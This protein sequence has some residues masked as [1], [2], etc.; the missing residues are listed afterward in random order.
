MKKSRLNAFNVLFLFLFLG[1][2][3]TGGSK[4]MDHNVTNQSTP[5]IV[6]I[7]MDD[8]GYGDPES[9]GGGPYHTPNMNK[10]AAEGMRFTNFYAAQ[11]VCSASRTGLLTG[12]YPTRVGISGALNH[13]SKI[14]L[15]PAEETIAELLHAKGYRTSMI[16]KWHLG[17]KEPFMPL[18]QGFDEFFGL[19]YSND[20]WPVYY[21]GKPYTDTSS[22]RSTYP[23]LPLYDGN[24]IVKKIKTLDDQS[25]LTTAYT[26]RA[27]KFIKENKARPFFLYLAHSMVHVP[28]AVS[29]RFKGKS[30]A[31]LFG[32][33]MEEVDWSL[34]EVMRSLKENG[35]AENTVVIFTSD[36]G[37]WLTFGNHAGNT[38]GLREG[39]GTHWDGGLKVP[40]MV[41][42]PGKIPAGTICHNLS[43]TMDLL[44]TIVNLC[45]AKM[46]TQTIDG[47]NIRDL[48][49]AKK[50][51]DPR[52]EFVYYYDKNNLK[53]VRDKRWKLVFPSRSQT[54]HT[55]AT[56]GNDGFPGKYATDTVHLAL[57][58]LSVDPGED[59]DVKD[60]HPEIVQQLTTVANRYRKEIGDGL[61]NQVGY[62]VRPPAKLP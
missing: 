9:Y 15:N 39:K 17:S 31:G 41:K 50:E 20:M 43:T 62:A 21:D 46:P 32:D 40:F 34:G 5:N 38:G 51:A 61:T 23:P 59:R 24:T 7:F 53:A 27:K 12:C 8:M 1:A 58:D 26:E 30:G 47:V 56:I 16:G 28:L 60:Q 36:N 37:P 33:V 29:D 54:Y 22:F 44:P 13:Q 57:Y 3:L 14:A 18:Q 45:S 55:P 42:W 48:F 19:P 11:A 10:M 49:F 25:T 35:I 52:K 2:F 6:I 4:P